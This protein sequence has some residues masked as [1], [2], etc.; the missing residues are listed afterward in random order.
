MIFECKQCD[1]T[2]QIYT[3]KTGDV[4]LCGTCGKEME[5]VKTY[6]GFPHIKKPLKDMRPPK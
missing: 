3:W 2:T 5:F 4:I 6:T 1:K